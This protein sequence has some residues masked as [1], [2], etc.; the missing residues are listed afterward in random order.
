MGLMSWIAYEQ[1]AV[2]LFKNILPPLIYSH[3]AELL[4]I[5]EGL[6]LFSTRN[7]GALVV[8]SDSSN[9]IA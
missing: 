8:E 2:Y 5:L 9:A 1:Y 4:A 7:E 3:E 6:I